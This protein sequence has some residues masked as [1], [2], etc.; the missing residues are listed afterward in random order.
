M[1][2][3]TRSGWSRVPIR[4]GFTKEV[5]RPKRFIIHRGLSTGGLVVHTSLQCPFIR[6]FVYTRDELSSGTL[7]ISVG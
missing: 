2:W 5:R 4:F 3:K 1:M 6:D 7:W